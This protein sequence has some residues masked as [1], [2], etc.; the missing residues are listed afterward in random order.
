VVR[1]HEAISGGL[2]R[3]AVLHQPDPV[4]AH[5][6]RGVRSGRGK[7]LLLAAESVPRRAF[8][9]R[10]LRVRT[11]RWVDARSSSR[12]SVEVPVGKDARLSKEQRAVRQ[13]SRVGH[14]SDSSQGGVSR[15]S[16]SVPE[17]AGLVAEQQSRPARLL[18]VPSVGEIGHDVGY[19]SR[20]GAG[21]PRLRLCRKARAAPF[22][23]SRGVVSARVSG[24]SPGWVG[25]ARSPASRS[26]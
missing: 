6:C 2:K 24:S 10:A 25:G 14:C 9:R 12:A 1:L 3:L 11:I 4:G 7:S 22:W 15:G 23:S 19:C 17:T 8:S 5:S 18:V 21:A 16:S 20:R 26:D 13:P